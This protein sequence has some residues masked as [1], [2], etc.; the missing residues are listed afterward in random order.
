MNDDRTNS[1]DSGTA[2]EPE[3]TQK[4]SRTIGGEKTL[5]A[6]D[7]GTATGA[8]PTSYGAGGATDSLEEGADDAV[9][10]GG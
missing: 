4:N 10:G 3:L 8:G 9:D 5:A 7:T 2:H 1:G 6:D